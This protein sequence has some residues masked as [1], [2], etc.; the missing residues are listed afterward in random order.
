MFTPSLFLLLVSA[1][2]HAGGYTSQD[3]FQAK[4]RGMPALRYATEGA[5][6]WRGALSW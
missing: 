6:A 2:A 3:L 1:V 5:G 4:A